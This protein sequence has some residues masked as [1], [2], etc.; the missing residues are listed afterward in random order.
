MIK[1]ADDYIQKTFGI[2][3]YKDGIARSRK[4]KEGCSTII[5]LIRNEEK[6]I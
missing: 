4:E 6:K 3:N 1:E 2:R 5:S